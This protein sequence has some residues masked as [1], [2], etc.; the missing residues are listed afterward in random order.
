MTCFS[1]TGKKL[2]FSVMCPLQPGS[3][4][5]C[6]PHDFIVDVVQIF[7]E[8]DDLCAQPIGWNSKIRKTN[9]H[10]FLWA[11]ASVQDMHDFRRY[12]ERLLEVRWNN[13]VDSR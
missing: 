10:D 12:T 6:D 7:I 4:W 1:Q 2:T 11:D 5:I 13:S 9:F 8:D 3:Y